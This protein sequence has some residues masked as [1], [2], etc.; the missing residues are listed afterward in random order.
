MKDTTQ[1]Q[2]N[3]RHAQSKIRG[4]GEGS[5]CGTSIPFLGSQPSDPSVCV[6]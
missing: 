1:E 4:G 2:P 3:G 5:L 6:D